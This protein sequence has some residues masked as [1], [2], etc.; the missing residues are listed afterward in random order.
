MSKT[1]R[2]K[3]LET[4]NNVIAEKG[5]S[6]FTLETVAQE[7]SV[8]KGGLLYHFPNKESLIE[9]L[10]EGYTN[11][12][13][14]RVND[15]ISQI[16]NPVSY[17]FLRVFIEESFEQLE[18]DKNITMGLLAA[19]SSNR[20]LLNPMTEFNNEWQRIIERTNDPE[21]ATIIRLATDGLIYSELFQI[22]V[23]SDEMR[24]RVLA[25]LLKLAEENCK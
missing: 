5:L 13:N 2:E 15:N 11:Q 14:Y 25:R 8:S 24:N 6:H 18:I 12:F 4:A 22:N 1:V 20:E 16:D 7:A 9:N 17:D 19:V 21:L 3:I 10:I 23:I